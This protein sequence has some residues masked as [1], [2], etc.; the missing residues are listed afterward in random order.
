MQYVDLTCPEVEKTQLQ[1]TPSHI[2]GITRIY[3]NTYTSLGNN[4]FGSGYIPPANGNPGYNY[5]LGT[6]LWNDNYTSNYTPAV[7]WMLQQRIQ[8]TTK[9]V[10]IAPSVNFKVIA[11]P[12]N[13]GWN[14]YRNYD[15]GFG[16][17][18]YY[19]YPSEMYNDSV[20]LKY[21]T[22]SSTETPSWLMFSIGWMGQKPKDQQNA[23]LRLSPNRTPKN[24][25]QENPEN[26]E[27]KYFGNTDDLVIVWDWNDPN[28][29]KDMCLELGFSISDLKPETAVSPMPPSP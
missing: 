29:C 14:L 4:T 23:T 1:I 15:L 19:P 10:L 3:A 2:S 9:Q 27:K 5:D 22:I 8:F 20:Q 28:Y 16:G 25:E 11:N 12:T 18:D 17:I 6:G 21:S 26:P 7:F 24:G 13:S